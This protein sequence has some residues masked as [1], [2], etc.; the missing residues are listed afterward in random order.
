M[1]SDAETERNLSLNKDR[2]SGVI[3]RRDPSSAAQFREEI[4]REYRAEI[5]QL[6]EE[7]QDQQQQ[8]TELKADLQ[9]VKKNMDDQ[10]EVMTA[11]RLIIHA[12]IALKTVVIVLIALTAAIGGIAASMEAFKQWFK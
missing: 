2:R 3:D 10:N 9:T 4:G 7:K 8:I 6:R 5:R 1:T 12:G 11:M